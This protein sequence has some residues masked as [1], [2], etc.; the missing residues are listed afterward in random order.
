M[1]ISDSFRDT[2]RTRHILRQFH[3]VRY[4]VD[5]GWCSLHWV[6]TDLQ[7]ADALSK[8]LAP[9]AATYQELRK[10]SEVQVDS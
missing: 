3:Y 6:P 1:A 7:L 4:Q 10:A 2:K 9:T 5:G 8:A